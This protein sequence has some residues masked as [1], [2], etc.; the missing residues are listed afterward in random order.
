M[1]NAMQSNAKS[2]ANDS[3]AN[4]S[5]ASATSLIDIYVSIVYIVH[6]QYK[7]T[8]ILTLFANGISD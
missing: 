5:D 2:D 4:D 6:I 3:D 7:P 1:Y 8:I